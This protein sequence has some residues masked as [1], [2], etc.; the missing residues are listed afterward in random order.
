MIFCQPDILRRKSLAPNELMNQNAG[1][2]LQRNVEEK[3]TQKRKA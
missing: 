1:L 2:I 3:I